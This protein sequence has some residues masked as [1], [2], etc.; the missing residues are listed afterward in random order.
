MLL[1]QGIQ[2]ARDTAHYVY[3]GC[4]NFSTMQKKKQCGRMH[5]G[6]KSVE[7]NLIGKFIQFYEE[8]RK[9]GNRYS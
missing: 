1:S 5:Q 7:I 4:N 6:K 9:R 8:N 2:Y 3:V